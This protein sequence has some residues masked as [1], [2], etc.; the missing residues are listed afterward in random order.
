M[1]VVFLFISFQG[2]LHSVTTRSVPLIAK[3]QYPFATTI[4][5]DL[6]FPED[7][8]KITLEVPSKKSPEKESLHPKF[9]EYV[10]FKLNTNSMIV[11]RVIVYQYHMIHGI[12]H[13]PDVYVVT[14]QCYLNWEE[15]HIKPSFYDILAIGELKCSKVLINEESIKELRKQ[16]VDFMELAPWRNCFYGFLTNV[17]KMYYLK[18][19]RDHVLPHSYTFESF[20]ESPPFHYFFSFFTIDNNFQNTALPDFPG[21]TVLSFVGDGAYSFV[22]F[23]IYLDQEIFIKWPNGKENAKR[24]LEREVNFLKELEKSG[25]PH[26][27]RVLYHALD[28]SYAVMTPRGQKISNYS[29]SLPIIHEML[30]VLSAIH[31]IETVHCDIHPSTL[32]ICE[33]HA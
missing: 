28:Y 14:L 7:W 27:P 11:C 10:N 18:I 1:P 5:Q 25:V 31:R 3:R 17:L 19:I 21:V 13:W 33:G 8:R 20:E 12:H 22:F 30:E 32:I 23:G 26:V 24:E 29:L 4:Q 6:E 15:G 9:Y 2:Y 16:L